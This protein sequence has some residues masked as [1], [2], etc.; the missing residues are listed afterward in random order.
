LWGY[1]THRTVFLDCTQTGIH[2]ILRVPLNIPFE[3]SEIGLRINQAVSM[4]VSLMALS[5]ASL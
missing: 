2:H 3:S 5:M 1:F 4:R